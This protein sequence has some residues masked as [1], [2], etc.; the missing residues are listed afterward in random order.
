MIISHPDNLSRIEEIRKRHLAFSDPKA[1]ADAASEPVV[2]WQGFSVHGNEPSG[3]NAAVLYAYFLAASTS[4]QTEHQLR[5]AIIV[6]DP[7]INPD[8]APDLQPG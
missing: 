5:N 2:V 8:G 4:A 3:A 1:S 6:M 7:V